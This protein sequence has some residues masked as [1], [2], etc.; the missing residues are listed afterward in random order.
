MDCHRTF[1]MGS[2]IPVAICVLN[3]AKPTDRRDK[4][5]F[6]DANQDGCFRQGKA[7]NFLDREHIHKIVTAYRDFDDMDRFAHVAGLAEIEA[8]DFN[9][10]I[11]RYVDT[12]Q[13]IDVPSV[14]RGASAVEGN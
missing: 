6:V 2:A 11:S 1:S 14:G 12:S 13:P 4:V 7:Q 9:L 10:N 5:L 8:N 3:K